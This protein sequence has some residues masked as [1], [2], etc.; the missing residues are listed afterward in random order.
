MRPLRLLALVQKRPG[1][2]P[3][4]RFRLEQWAPHLARA[5]GI[6]V[7][8]DAFESPEL[9]A[10]LYRPGHVARKARLV[11]GDSLRR[12]RRRRLARGFDGVVV[13]REAT[14]LGGAMVERAIARS[15]VPLFYDFDDAIWLPHTAGSNGVLALAR[16]PWK[17][18]AVCRLA[19]SVTVGNTYLADYARRF[20]PSVDIVRTSIDVDRFDAAP[21]PPAEQPFTVVWTGSHSTLAHLETIRPALEA[22]GRAVP[23]RLRVI[24]DVA[25]PPLEHV[26][27][28]FVP[29]RA[30]REALDLAVGHVGVMPLPDTPSARGKCGCKALQYMAVA[31]PAVVSPV[32]IN[33][34]I[35]RDGENGLLATS[36]DEWTGQLLRLARDPALRAGLGDAGRRTVLDGFTA[37]ASAAAFARVVRGALGR[38]PGA[39]RAEP[40]PPAARA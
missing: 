23:T 29:W 7:D 2:A 24:C 18:G 40:G 13:L 25:P 15:G 38:E 28:E 39:A 35:V 4:Q 19:T 26:G 9:S 36:L 16:A 34:E 22:V 21:P 27:L 1:I 14:M 12:W 30:D 32:G 8:F 6:S 5:H 3:H 33:R 10:V 37:S 17:V 11:L 20:N 31:R